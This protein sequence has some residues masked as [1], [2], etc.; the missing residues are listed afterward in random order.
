MIHKLKT[1]IWSSKLRIRTGEVVQH[2]NGFYSNKTGVNSEPEMNGDS[3]WLYI[4]EV[5]KFK[6]FA[7][8]DAS[9]IKDEF[10]NNWREKLNIIDG[11][12][13]TNTDSTLLINPLEK[14]IDS[15][16]SIIED[17][18]KDI[19]TVV[20]SFTPLEIL[21]VYLNGSKLQNDQFDFTLPNIIYIG[22]AGSINR[23]SV[24]YRH[25]VTDLIQ[26]QQQQQ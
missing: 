4:G 24:Q 15:N 12:I 21:G 26:Q 14:T 6:S 8:K 5:E 16:T 23:I 2:K 3:N 11:S 10:I 19:D 1:K 17:Q 22:S 18:F 13:Y 25:L 7:A 20:L 9:N